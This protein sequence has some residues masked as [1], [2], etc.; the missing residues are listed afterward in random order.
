[1]K[2]GILFIWV[3]KELIGEVIDHFKDQKFEYIENLC[4]VYLDP[5]QHESTKALNNTDA[6]PCIARQHYPFLSKSHR[7]LLMLRKKPDHY[8]DE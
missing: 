1:M 2:D 7:T 4:H 3:E 6:T 5:A 8:K